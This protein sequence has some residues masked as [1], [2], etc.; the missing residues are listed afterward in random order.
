MIQFE[1]TISIDERSS[2]DSSSDECDEE[3]TSSGI[4]QVVSYN[5]KIENKESTSRRNCEESTS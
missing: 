4:F 2:K 1:I 5:E 3:A